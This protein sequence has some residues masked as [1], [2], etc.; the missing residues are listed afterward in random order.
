MPTPFALRPLRHA[1]AATAL[2][3]MGAIAAE[4]VTPEG[5]VAHYADLAH[6]TFE[7]ALIAAR[8][9]D[10]RID[11][12]LEAPSA[13]SLAAARL[14]W[15][16]ARVPYQQSEVFRFG[17]PVV[18]D[19]EGQLNAW[20][21]DEGLIDYVA[22][23]DYQHELGNAGATANLVASTSIQIGG[24]TL[25]VSELSPEL[26]AD[27]NEIGGSEANVA[28][29][30]HA[31]EFL[32][33]GQ[34]RHG[35]EAGNGERPASDYLT[36]DECTH[37]H[38][39][40]RGAYLDAVSDLLVSDL[41]WM[42]AQWTPNEG[43]NY[44]QALLAESAD[45]GLR[46]MLFGMGSLS[47][48]ELAGERMKVALAANS[49]EDEHD[50]FS[51]NTHNSHFY[52]GQGV[53]NVYLGQYQRLDGSMLDGPSLSDLVASEDAELDASLRAQLEASM[54]ELGELKQAAEAEQSPMAFDMMIA[55]GNEV[56][57]ALVNDAILALVTQ[58]GSIEQ[59]AGRL[60]VSQLQPDD[61]GHT[62]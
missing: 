29:G 26:L 52:N 15:L 48:G 44:R 28:T 1:I 31:I 54:A 41:E 5:V 17:N 38:C 53:Q 45:E 20:P 55:P 61:A 6:A 3:P 4:D 57:A 21:L 56:G 51:D 11:A 13:E 46:R 33:W 2:L 49:V 39:D 37:G 18:D 42:V 50:C 16:E 14:A 25:D 32:L 30:Y 59:A 7:D 36:G 10:A 22:S 9:L 43:D 47:L 19:W 60:G 23:D 24:E 40:R 12:L 62:F 8:T 58:T 35:F 34:D 27:L